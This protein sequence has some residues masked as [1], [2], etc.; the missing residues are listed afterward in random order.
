MNVKTATTYTKY[1]VTINVGDII[2][3]AGGSFVVSIEKSR[4]RWIIS[5]QPFK[6]DYRCRYNASYIALQLMNRGSVT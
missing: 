6:W 5:Y 1:G 4:T 3:L 2:P